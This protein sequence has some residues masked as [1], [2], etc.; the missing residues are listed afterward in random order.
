MTMTLVLPDGAEVKPVEFYRTL[1]QLCPGFNIG[2]HSNGAY[3]K[4]LIWDSRE[5]QHRL[6]PPDYQPVGLPEGEPSMVLLF[7]T[8]DA[9][10]Y[11]RPEV[12][13]HQGRFISAP[14]QMLPVSLPGGKRRKK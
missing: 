2:V 5:R 10:T 12:Y 1:A 6:E 11:C 9:L 8:D 4:L 3:T 7:M 13:D 14:P